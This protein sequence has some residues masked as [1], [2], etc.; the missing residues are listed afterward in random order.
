MNSWNFVFKLIA[1]PIKSYLAHPKEGKKEAL[2]SL[3]EKIPK[4]EV[5]AAENKNV[6]IIIT[7]TRTEEEDKA[8]NEQLEAIEILQLLALVSGF[9]TPKP[10]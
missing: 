1:M 9:N 5:L 3:L 6:L 4:C 7:D 10:Q 2:K 8:L